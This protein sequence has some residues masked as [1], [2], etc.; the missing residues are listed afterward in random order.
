MCVESNARSYRRTIARAQKPGEKG[1]YKGA[2]R[3]GF[4]R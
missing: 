2:L 1:K 3:R 4:L